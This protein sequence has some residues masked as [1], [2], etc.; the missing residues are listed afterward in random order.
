MAAC[1]RL[2]VKHFDTSPVY[3]A[4]TPNPLCVCPR[5]IEEFA[6]LYFRTNRIFGLTS[7]GRFDTKAEPA[8]YK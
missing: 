4:E 3:S 6:F 1:K 2:A 7:R 5:F 8:A